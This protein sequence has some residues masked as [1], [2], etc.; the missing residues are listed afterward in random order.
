[1]TQN[2]STSRPDYIGPDW[3]RCTDGLTLARRPPDSLRSDASLT[4]DSPW[5]QLVSVTLQAQGG[6]FHHAH[7]LLEIVEREPDTHLRDCAVIVFSLTAPDAQLERLAEVFEHPDH[8]TRLTAYEG[9]ARSC[10]P[11]LARALARHRS[12]TK[13]L[14][15]ERIMDHVSTLLEVDSDDLE[16]VDSPLDDDAYIARVD[17]RVE[18]LTA[19]HGR[20]TAIFRGEPLDAERLVEAIADL[21]AADEPEYGGGTIAFLFSLL[22]GMTGWPYAGCL[23][24]DCTPVL[25]KISHTLNSLRQ[26]GRLDSLVPGRRYFFGHA[27]P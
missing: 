9:A 13:G 19:R 7:R 27:L 20:Q 16:F 8:D 24:D 5:E 12:R 26:S 17:E 4:S 6:D 21:C 15:R 22:E 11:S 2:P 14:E 23:D 18:A 1:M 10:R 3:L 25:P